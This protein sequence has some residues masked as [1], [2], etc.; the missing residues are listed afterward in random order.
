[1]TAPPTHRRAVEDIAAPRLPGGIDTP[2]L[3]VDLDVAGQL[4]DA[5][6]RRPDVDGD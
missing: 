5:P 3:L 6:R 4:E 1:M 2:A